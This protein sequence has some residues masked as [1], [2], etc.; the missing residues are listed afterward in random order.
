MDKFLSCDWGTSSFRLRLVAY[1][2]L[3][4]TAEEKHDNGI[5][6]T[7]RSW[8]NA[9]ADP[10]KRQSYYLPVITNAIQKLREHLELDLAGIPVIISGMISAS[11][12]MLELPYKEI[13][14][15][16]DGADLEIK[17]LTIEGIDHKFIIIS[18]IKSDNDV[19]RGEETKIIGCA[20]HFTHDEQ[21]QLLIFPGTH[22]KHVTIQNKKITGIKT[23]MTGEFFDLLVNHSI[24]AS[25]VKKN[26]EFDEPANQASFTKGVQDSVT[27]NLLHASFLVRTNTLLK[28]IPKENNYYYLSGLLIGTELKDAAADQSAVYLCGGADLTRFYKLACDLLSITI[29][30]EIDADEALLNG[31]KQIY[32]QLFK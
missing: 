6:S 18:G 31:Q 3:A 7:F 12:G 22:T 5:A 21:G 17:K 13:P 32:K 14:I 1:E 24:L 4:I 2:T 28:N 26:A 25:S 19:I 11:I 9:G 29:L 15:T 23:Y 16:E 30:M 27:N 10:E 20:A 8:Q